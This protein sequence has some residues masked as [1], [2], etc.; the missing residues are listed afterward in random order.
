MQVGLDHDTLFEFTCWFTVGMVGEAFWRRARVT[1]AGPIMEARWGSPNVELYRF[2][3]VGTDRYWCYL[4]T[5]CAD[6]SD[7]LGPPTP[8]TA[9]NRAAALRYEVRQLPGYLPDV[10]WIG[11]RRRHPGLAEVR[12]TV[13]RGYGIEVMEIDQE[14]P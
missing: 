10:D 4:G 13:R 14:F 2:S 5:T 6:G 12:R 9:A 3:T 1:R 7:I 11:V 8:S